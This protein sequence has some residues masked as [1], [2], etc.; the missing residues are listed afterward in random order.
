[1]G[2][3]RTFRIFP[4]LMESACAF[5]RILIVD[6]HFVVRRGVQLILLGTFPDAVFA[7]A[8]TVDEALGH[9]RQHAW[10]LAFLD[11]HL[12]GLSGL[13]LLQIIK[14]EHPKLP[15]I[16]LTM[17]PENQFA[18]RVLRAG[19]AGY[20]TK[21]SVD[22]ELVRAAKTVLG[23]KKYITAAVAQQL[24][25]HVGQDSSTLPHEG[26]SGR[27]FRV[28]CMIASGK[29][30]KEIGGELEL[31]VKTVSTYRMRLMEKMGL[32][33]NSALTHYALQHRL[34]DPDV[35]SAQSFSPV[36]G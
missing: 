1:M 34:I 9:L 36:H 27:E 30:I 32:G 12:P 3:S 17:N 25:S 33:S 2:T 24:A 15:A 21:D 11:V 22:E 10:D 26:L 18:V 29:T 20:L 35:L 28:L 23:G 5:P 19:A 14:R 8:G 16:I 13:D 7:M 31:S 6:D 4:V